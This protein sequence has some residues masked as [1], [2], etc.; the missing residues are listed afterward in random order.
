LVDGC[1]GEATMTE[2]LSERWLKAIDSVTGDWHS[3]SE[4]FP[5]LIAETDKAEQERDTLNLKVMDIEPSYEAALKEIK[6]QR[7][8]AER[9]EAKLKELGITID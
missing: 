4:G 7:K 6:I 9:A 5:E 1:R 3:E 2:K 8:R